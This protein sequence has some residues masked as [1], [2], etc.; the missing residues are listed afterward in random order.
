MTF[1]LKKFLD[2]IHT[3]LWLTILIAIIIILRVPS[4][5]E[6]YSY[7]DE[8]IYLTLGQGIRQGIPL[9]AGLHDNKPP[10]L[11]IFAA[12]ANNLFWFKAILTF[13]SIGTIIV[14]WKLVRALFPKK[15]SL[16]KVTLIIFSL[17]ITTPLFEGNIANAEVFMIGP[18]ILAF[19]ILLTRK[20][21]PRNLIISGTLFSTATLFKFP[22]AFDM[23][24]IFAFWLITIKTDKQKLT[25][26]LKKIFQN[27]SYLIIGFLIPIGLTLIWFGTKGSLREYINA[28]FL[29]NIGYL[30]SWRLD[31]TR[32]PFLIRNRPLLIRGLIVL[33]GLFTLY[34]KRKKLPRNFIF[35]TSWILFALF[36]VTLSERPYP[37]YLIQIVPPLSILFGMLFTDK[38]I[39]QSFV[40]IPLALAFLAPT[41]Y[42]FW[43][44][45][46]FYYYARFI[47]FSSGS[48]SRNEYVS[49]FSEKVP[50]NYKIAEFVTSITNPKDKIFVWGDDAKIYALTRRL[51]PIKYV[52]DY[53]IK[54][55]SSQDM[56]IKLLKKNPPKIIVYLPESDP[57]PSLTNFLKERYINLTFIDKAEIWKL[58]KLNKLN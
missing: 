33:L 41:Y 19:L 24:S 51:P 47:E 14:F 6:P 2:K 39:F 53:H 11:Y 1:S 34:W 16:Q 52:T 38:T 17:L 23:L 49:S 37:H 12:V 45:P 56:V 43:H 25:R 40:T 42:H 35:T 18:I 58:I 50:R 21:T 26:N 57:F 4:F 46:I 29:Q 48:L 31:S 20:L 10:L 54:D 9:Y 22:A 15:I 3:P 32:V 30:S 55:F 44:Y 28:A 13:W 27:S 7:G 5:F 8:S 36:A